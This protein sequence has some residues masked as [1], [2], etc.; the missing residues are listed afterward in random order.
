METTFENAQV[1]DNVWDEHT[2]EYGDIYSIQEG[3]LHVNFKNFSKCYT[4]S[5]KIVGCAI[6]TLY[7]DKL[8]IPERP[9]RKVKKVIEGW[10]NIYPDSGLYLFESRAN[11]RALPSRLGKAH[12]IHHEYEVEE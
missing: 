1:G 12:F 6:R 11:K 4:A 9:K 5:G 7:W 3:I 8:V 2:Q 10:Y